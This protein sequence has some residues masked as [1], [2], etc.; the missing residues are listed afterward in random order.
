MAC[1]GLLTVCLIRPPATEPP[2]PPAPAAGLAGH[3]LFQDV[4]GKRARGAGA[5]ALGVDTAFRRLPP[6]LCRISLP[7]SP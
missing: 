1:A 4:S 7:V 5:T 6:G 2:R 3:A